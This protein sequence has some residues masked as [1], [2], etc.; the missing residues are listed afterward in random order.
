[1]TAP[2]ARDEA[3][4]VVTQYLIAQAAMYFVA[5]RAVGN[6]PLDA[7]DAVVERFDALTSPPNST[8]LF[9]ALNLLQEA[10]SSA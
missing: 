5:R 10:G 1:M 6:M 3:V 9:D 4:E 8:R 7:Q 2:L